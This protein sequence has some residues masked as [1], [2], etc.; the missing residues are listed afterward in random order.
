[1][2]RFP[3][4]TGVTRRV[5]VGGAVAATIVA[6]A[7][8]EEDLRGDRLLKE[9]ERKC[10]AEGKP[11]SFA[12]YRPAPIP[13]SENLFRA[14]VIAR[15]F[16]GRETDRSAW[17]A[18]EADKPP[19]DK[20]SKILGNWMQGQRSDFDQAYPALGMVP[21]SQSKPDP[22]A[23]ARLVLETLHGIRPDLDALDLAA[24]VRPQEQIEFGEDYIPSFRALRFL[25]R[26]LNLS[27]VA[28]LELGQTDKA[29]GD[30]YASLRLA[31]GA[32]RF[33]HHL[34]LMMANVMASISLQP[35]WE[36]CVEHA[37]RE[38]Q[39]AGLQRVL[40]ELHLLQDL[41]LAFAAGRAAYESG[42]LSNLRRPWW[43]PLGWWKMNIVRLFEMHA[44]GGDARWFD[45]ERERIDLGALEHSDALVDRLRRS[46]SPFDW[47]I[48]HEAWGSKITFF[49]GFGQNRIELARVAC[50][51]ERFRLAHGHLPAELSE[52]VP[53]YLES[54]PRDVIDHAPLRYDRSRADQ[55]RIYSVGL[56]GFEAHAWPGKPDLVSSASKEG[57]WAWEQT[58]DPGPP[59][60]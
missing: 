55:F 31:E 25:T 11:L 58:D 52:L 3:S 34:T 40:S 6:A 27:A 15:F 49:A 50:A 60:G 35:I 33:P 42:Y 21:P 32:E 59:R 17:T 28:E 29:Y 44:G 26:A 19:L 39:L 46:H 38:D 18:Y 16:T 9:F 54:V 48:R 1:M 23:G 56:S 13:E 14:P 30:I 4:W 51:L 2:K 10:E 5:L 57:Y 22:K 20:L 8:I 43:M 7:W 37:W 53:T 41:P 12:H 45:S 36:G 47:L 24:R